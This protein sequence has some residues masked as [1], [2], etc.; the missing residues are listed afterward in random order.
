MED[1][2]ASVAH[3]VEALLDRM[4]SFYSQRL[5]QVDI[6]KYFLMGK[7]LGKGSY[8]KVFLTNDRKTGQR[9]ASK[10]MD[11]SR[12]SQESFLREF[13]ISS[14]LSSHPNI[15]G[16]C[17]AIFKTTNNFVF[18]QELAPAGDLFSLIIPN[19]TSQFEPFRPGHTTTPNAFSDQ[20]TRIYYK[21]PR[22]VT[23]AKE[24]ED[25]QSK[26]LDCVGIPEDAAKRCAVQISSALKFIAKNGLVHMD[27]KPE[28][29][30]VF[31]KECHCIKITDFG[32][33]KVRGTVIRSRCGSQSYMA[34][35][36]RNVTVSGGLVVDG[37]LDVWAFGVIIFCLLTGKFPWRVAILDDGGYKRFVE[38]Q[39]NFKMANPPKAWKRVPPKIQRMFNGLLA[40]DYSKRSQSTEVLK[41]TNESWKEK[42]ADSAT[43]G[44][45]EDPIETDS[46][47]Q[48]EDSSVSHQNTSQ[49][50]RVSNTSTVNSMS[51]SSVS[52]TNTSGSQSEMSPEAQEDN[53]EE[54][55]IVFDDEFSLHIGAEVDVG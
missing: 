2:M 50:S 44:E 29:I 33:A 24:N 52:T 46:T 18:T 55:L 6:Q 31:D 36:M 15:I 20:P 12:I 43:R 19:S 42:T 8:G 21:S 40:I 53:M 10:F 17:D 35:E 27:L 34:P 51:S 22:P 1:T 54:A 39:N 25:L 5:R 47:A 30:L 9:M 41:Y 38:W 14:F 49:S 3:D 7:E 11:R 13:S 16:C 45:E 26:D 32:L 37:S 48:S 4:V 23:R 28:N